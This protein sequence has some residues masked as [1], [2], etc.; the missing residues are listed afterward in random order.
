MRS[1][2]G[3]AWTASSDYRFHRDRLRC[4][5]S[6]L[7]RIHHRF[8]IEPAT[9]ED[10]AEYLAFRLKGA[11]VDQEL[12]SRESV[13]TLHEASAGSLREAARRKRKIVDREAV[14]RVAE[15]LTASLD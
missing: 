7:T 13:V 14:A 3:F 10:T 11:G 5:R 12:F 15:A 2:L 9:A 8:L 6:L 1:S 4:H